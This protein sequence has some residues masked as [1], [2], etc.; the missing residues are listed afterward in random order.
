MICPS[1][2]L[3]AVIV[4]QLVTQPP[5][6][7]GCRSPDPLTVNR[8]DSEPEVP[9]GRRRGH[10]PRLLGTA[11]WSQLAWLHGDIGPRLRCHPRQDRSAAERCPGRRL[12]DRHGGHPVDRAGLGGAPGRGADRPGPGRLRLDRRRLGHRDGS[13]HPGQRSRLGEAGTGQPREPRQAWAAVSC[14]LHEPVPGHRGGQRLGRRWSHL[15][16]RA[17]DRQLE[18]QPV[19]GRG[20]A[21]KCW[22]PVPGN[23]RAVPQRRILRR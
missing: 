16:C 3:F 7:C 1:P 13:R 5:Y 19:P 17:V 15:G 20:R 11:G 8:Q 9:K 14:C 2:R 18:P 10:G 6:F 23:R 22:R 12:R 21:G 4:T